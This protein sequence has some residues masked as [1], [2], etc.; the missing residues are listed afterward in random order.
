[1]KQYAAAPHNVV[2]I[3]LLESYK[4]A[5]QHEALVKFLLQAVEGSAS[6]ELYDFAFKYY[7]TRLSSLSEALPV[8]I[9]QFP[10]IPRKHVAFIC[11]SCGYESQAMQWNCPSC[12][13]WSSLK[14]V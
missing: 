5:D 3:E 6:F 8:L 10:S 1:V 9:N 2:A 14:P 12:K 7:S 4:V 11:N 13:A